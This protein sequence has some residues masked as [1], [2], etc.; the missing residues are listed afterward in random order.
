[1]ILRAADW[2]FQVDL[3]KTREMTEGYSKDHCTCGYCQNYY[4]TVEDHYPNLKPALAEFGI[5]IHGPIEVMPFEPTLVLVCYRVWGKILQWG[6]TRLFVDGISITPEATEEEDVFLLWVGEMALP[7]VQHI[8]PEDVISP[9]NL[10][11]FLE[12]MQDTW[13]LRHENAILFS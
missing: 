7:W 2:K 4:D 10:P 3:E 13:A 5:H 12:R 1:M 11:E 8:D 9:A 6:H